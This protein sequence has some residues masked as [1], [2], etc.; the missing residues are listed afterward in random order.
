MKKKFNLFYAS[1][2]VA[3]KN[4]MTVVEA[5]DILRKKHQEL[6]FK[7]TL[8]GEGKLQNQVFFVTKT[9]SKNEFRIKNVLIQELKVKFQL[10]SL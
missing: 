1:R 7:L 6:D 10:Y 4:P 2:F 8:A 5:I 9:M 3:T